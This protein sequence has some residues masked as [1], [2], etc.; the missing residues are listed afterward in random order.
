MSGGGGA[1][2]RLTRVTVNFLAVLRLERLQRTASGSK[3]N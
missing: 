3:C 1:I 2:N